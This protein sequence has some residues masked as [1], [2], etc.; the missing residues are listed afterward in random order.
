[1]LNND[2]LQEITIFLFY[3]VYGTCIHRNGKNLNTARVDPKFLQVACTV[4]LIA[5]VPRRKLHLHKIISDCLRPKK[6]NYA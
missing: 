6:T 5:N 2:C 3:F 4:G 1:M